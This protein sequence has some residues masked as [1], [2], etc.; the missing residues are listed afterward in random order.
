M[1]QTAAR[2]EGHW[3]TTGG[4]ISPS[5]CFAGDHY[6]VNTGGRYFQ[7]EKKHQGCPPPTRGWPHLAEVPHVEEVE[8]VEQLAVAQAELVVAHLEKRPNVLQAQK[9]QGQRRR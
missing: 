6:V 4:I 5:D 9:L 1:D 8:G 7:V 3:P 2:L